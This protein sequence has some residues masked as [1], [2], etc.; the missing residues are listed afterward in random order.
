MQIVERLQQNQAT[1][2]RISNGNEIAI[3]DFQVNDIVW[4]KLKGSPFWPAKIERIYGQRNQ[5]LEVF[6]FNDYRRSK[7]NKGQAQPFLRNFRKHAKSFNH[8]I[9][10]EAAAKE[11]ILY[12]T[13]TL[14]HL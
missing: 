7:V 1:N 6:W 3:I 2:D 8:H 11:A 13:S 4:V 10:L 9:G 14:N 5:M 12:G